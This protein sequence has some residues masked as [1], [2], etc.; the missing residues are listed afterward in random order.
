MVLHKTCSLH[1]CT[2]LT[3]ELTINVASTDTSTWGG[4][5]I[6]VPSSLTVKVVSEDV[7]SAILSAATS[8]NIYTVNCNIEVQ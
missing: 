1:G 5:F 3:G 7:K 2:S 4:I 8:G 6:R